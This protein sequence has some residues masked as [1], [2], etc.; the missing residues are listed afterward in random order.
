[1]KKADSNK[2]SAGWSVGYNRRV[3]ATEFIRAA[4]RYLQGKQYSRALE[5]LRY[6]QN[7]EPDNKYIIAII[8]RVLSLS[9]TEANP[10][11][12]DPNR[13]LSVTVGPSFE[14]GI[15][16]VDNSPVEF[17][18]H[19]LIKE[20]TSIARG[21][22]KI[23]LPEAAF[24]ALMKAY[25]IDP[26]DPEVVSCERE[27]IPVW[28]SARANSH[29]PPPTETIAISTSELNDIPGTNAEPL[30][31]VAEV[32]EPLAAPPELRIIREF[33]DF[34]EPPADDD[35]AAEISPPPTPTS[36]DSF[37][38]VRA[39]E[40]TE[41][42]PP[43]PAMPEDQWESV[44]PRRHDSSPDEEAQRV[45]AL[46]QQKESERREREREIYRAASRLPR[47]FEDTQKDDPGFHLSRT[48]RA[49][50]AA[51]GILRRFKKQ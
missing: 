42:P 31:T 49:T 8:E 17:P 22:V 21:Y 19:E 32:P 10:A 15:K 26:I 28:N 35:S 50:R 51:R 6:A 45:E 30:E 5:Q 24:N 27:V 7:C 44:R 29:P 2:P 46:M 12:P 9:T 25:L 39:P 40:L 1:M 13:Y 36:E 41:A 43:A 20:F 38:I 37:E 23:G 33:S 11:Q 16:P 14:E 3:S 47:I 48:S 4:E 34:D 18:Q